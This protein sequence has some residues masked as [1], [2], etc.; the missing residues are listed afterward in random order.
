MV[1]QLSFPLAEL[2]HDLRWQF[3]Q[4]RLAHLDAVEAMAHARKTIAQSRGLMALID[5]QLAQPLVQDWS[6]SGSRPGPPFSPL[7]EEKAPASP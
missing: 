5:R 6:V 3:Q 2:R 7:T 4:A 1:G